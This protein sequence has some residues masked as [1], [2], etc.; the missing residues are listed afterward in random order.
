MPQVTDGPKEL[1][2]LLESVY[3]S[4][5]KQYKGDEGKASAVAWAAAKQAGWEKNEKTGEWEKK[6]KPKEKAGEN[7]SKERMNEKL[8]LGEYDVSTNDD[9]T[10]N[11]LSVPVFATVEKDGK[12]YD[13]EW[14]KAA[15]ANFEAQKKET[16]YLPP[17]IVGHNTDDGSE[18][19]AV[20]LLDKITAA[21]KQLL[22]DLVRIPAEVFEKIKKGTWPSRSVE[23]WHAQ[24]RVT[25]LALLGGST[26]V[27]KFHPIHFAEAPEGELEWVSF[28][29][30]AE[31]Q[32]KFDPTITLAQRVAK[33]Q[34][35][36]ETRDIQWQANDMVMEI[37]RDKSLT[38]AQ[39]KEYITTVLDEYET[40]LIA[41]AGTSFQDDKTKGSKPMI[42]EGRKKMA[43]EKTVKTD[44]FTDEQTIALEAIVAERV[45]DATTDITKE[46][47]AFAERATES[48]KEIKRLKE[49]ADNAKKALTERE[50]ADLKAGIDRFLEDLRGKGVN[51]GFLDESGIAVFMQTLAE[52]KAI[53]KFSEKQETETTKF[54]QMK[55]VISTLVDLAEKK[56]LIV[57]KGE[58]APAG[59]QAHSFS[60]GD[61]SATVMVEGK[62]VDAASVE[63]DKVIR[64]MAEERK[65]DLSK[66]KGIAYAQLYQ[67]IG[68]A[69]E[70]AEK[71][72][73]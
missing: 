71:A 30:L 64:R 59:E 11:I 40:L 44:L 52:D 73:K 33:R 14:M 27:H 9:G 2:D 15:A 68:R 6:E 56:T 70:K 62:A 46:K 66:D 32:L 41:A 54:D 67:E 45:K 50:K 61:D 65:I 47:A 1:N 39:K 20:G 43:E 35:E 17:V 51:A 63:T 36:E 7:M 13:E 48:E 18:K 16:G 23:T 49:E 60:Q 3:Q 25:A 12:V 19:E 24:K 53:Q 28:A 38:T 57:P 4:A 31:G 26:P 37:M 22:A 5:L 21:G 10:F 58:I 55:S 8:K 29:A 42:E 72:K 69:K 34:E